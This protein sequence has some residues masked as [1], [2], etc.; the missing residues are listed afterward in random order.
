M[1]TYDEGIIEGVSLELRLCR[2]IFH[3]PLSKYLF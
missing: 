2:A 1:K 3:T